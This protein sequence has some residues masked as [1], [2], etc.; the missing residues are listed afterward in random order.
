MVSG[1][2]QPTREELE[3]ALRTARGKLESLRERSADASGTDVVE[4]TGSGGLAGSPDLREEIA[5]L[6]RALGASRS[7][8]RGES[9]DVRH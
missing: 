6:E 7:S 4:G 2:T 9:A 1:H 5:E 3:R 8:D